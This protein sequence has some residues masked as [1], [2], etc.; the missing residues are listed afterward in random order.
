MI[1]FSLLLSMLAT[2]VMALTGCGGAGNGV[3][4]K[5][6][7]SG[8]VTI[9]SNS[10]PVPGVLVE[11]WPRK[12][13]PDVPGWDAKA[14]GVHTAADGTYTVTDVPEGQFIVQVSTDDRVALGHSAYL[15][16][17]DHTT[18]GP[19]EVDISIPHGP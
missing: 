6:T 15:V 3:T 4:N 17:V 18:V 13:G 14:H 5:I 9:T 8:M 12:D 19:M 7:I 10:A 16:V 1:R 2:L 11:V